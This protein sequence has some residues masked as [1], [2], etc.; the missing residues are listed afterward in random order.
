MGMK[1]ESNRLRNAGELTFKGRKTLEDSFKD[2]YAKLDKGQWFVINYYGVRGIGKTRLCMELRK[3]LFNN[4]QTDDK[5]KK[6]TKSKSIILNFAGGEN[7]KW[8][9]VRILESL[10]NKFETECDYELINFRYALYRY[11]CEKGLDKDAPEIKCLEKKPFLCALLNL[12]G[13]VPGAG[14]VINA[15]ANIVDTIAIEKKRKKVENNEKVLNWEF[16]G[17]NEIVARLE[18]IF[19]EDITQYLNKEKKPVVI[20]LDAY[21]N[22]QRCSE[23]MREADGK[24]TREE[25]EKLLWGKRGLIRQMPNV[26]WVIAGVEKLTWG[27]KDIF[28]KE[29]EGEGK[30]IIYKPIMKMKAD[31]VKKI[32]NDAEIN[33]TEVMNVIVQ[34]SEGIPAHVVEAI[35]TYRRLLDDSRQPT[36]ADFDKEYQEL[37]SDFVEELKSEDSERVQTLACLETWREEEISILF[38]K[39]FDIQDEPQL[40]SCIIE[41]D[42]KYKLQDSV[43]KIAYEKSSQQIKEKC[44]K[45]LK[46][47]ESDKTVTQIE[48]EHSILRKMELQLMIIATLDE[49]EKY[50]KVKLFFDE[51]IEYVR[52]WIYD[53]FF[54]KTILEKMRDSIP[55]QTVPDIYAYTLVVYQAY[56]CEYE[57]NYKLAKQYLNLIELANFECEP[58]GETEALRLYVEAVSTGSGQAY[59]DVI[60]WLNYCKDDVTKIN[61]LFGYARH[62]RA[63][64]K[65]EEAFE[66]CEK[67]MTI[68]AGMKMDSIRAGF[69]CGIL[70]T[71]AKIKT[72]NYD[73][74]M[75]LQ[76]L[77][78]AEAIIENFDETVDQN[79]LVWFSQ[80]YSWHS[81]LSELESEKL[82]YA[83]RALDINKRAYKLNQNVLT[84]S[85]VADGYKTVAC[86]MPLYDERM[87]TYFNKAIEMYEELYREEKQSCSSIECFW[88]YNVDVNTLTEWILTA[89][90]A[91]EKTADENY[92]I[93]CKKAIEEEYKPLIMS[94]LNE[95]VLEKAKS[96]LEDYWEIANL[97]YGR[98]TIDQECREEWAWQAKM[99]G[100]VHYFLGNR[101]EVYSC[102]SSEN[103]YRKILARS[104]EPE[105]LRIYADSCIRFVLLC[106]YGCR[107]FEFVLKKAFRYLLEGAEVLNLAMENIKT[108][109]YSYICYEIA[110]DYHEALKMLFEIYN[111]RGE[112][113]KC[114]ILVEYMENFNSI[115]L[116]SGQKNIFI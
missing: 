80:V 11:Y 74:Q 88:I 70:L 29:N 25:L 19:C 55:E 41:N 2:V 97:V 113:E 27:E 99:L 60:R 94:Y 5:K 37:V 98:P 23:V 76:L 95:R 9:K 7:E 14:E 63:E 68:L 84:K 109:K 92:L 22:I 72:E 45:Y 65:D 77:T 89:Q 51:N 10:A 21:E 90:S 15:S 20:F 57:G 79:A 32:I 114:Q 105:Y 66:Y 100:R 6:K 34:R 104:G 31:D 106:E 87:L 101:K 69:E 33:D 47:R 56:R 116:Q 35:R 108:G 49:S 62:L 54:F 46:D 96:L 112:D 83:K 115:M 61:I 91:F 39:M 111:R 86:L 36:K 40:S 1:A 16:L 52:K 93:V 59:S 85:N 71:E 13:N 110:K 82:W 18:E 28:W 4:F 30:S 73:S 17:E 43:Q 81:D 44:I 64:E 12:A 50:W 53:D 67:A 103:M 26:L 38:G 102:W 42:G 58:G 24:G 107:D 3:N 75:A 78:Q 48:R 8:D